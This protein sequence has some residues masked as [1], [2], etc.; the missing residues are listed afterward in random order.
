MTSLLRERCHFTRQLATLVAAGLPLLDSLSSMAKSEQSTQMRHLI[1]QLCV[2]LEQGC[3]FHLALR[4]LNY[5]DTLYCELVGA[6]EMA[7]NLDQVLERLAVL[8]EKRQALHSQIRTALAYPCA[9]L[10]ITMVV[11]AVI[12]VWVVPVF[13][14]IFSS[15]GAD[16]PALTMF[17]L[18]MSRWLSNGGAVWALLALCSLYIP[19]R[20]VMNKPGF[21]LWRDTTLLRLPLFGA[22]VHQSQLSLWT[23]T[24]SDLLKAGVP[25]LD[26]LEVVAA[27][28]TNRCLG[29]STIFIRNKIKHGASLEGAMSSLSSISSQAHVFPPMLI[30][31]IAVGEQSGSLD[32][33]LAK[34]SQQLNTQV[35]NLLRQFTQLLEPAM[36]VVL[37]LLMGGL[38]VALYLPVF[39]L[40]QLL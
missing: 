30:Q 34:M 37:G 21:Q 22:M 11:V 12:M 39:Q 32:S 10:L 27:S 6:A 20:S 7:G 29:M 40:G 13:E 1:A 8:L 28:S 17:V 5:F 26:A 36:M 24:L 3:S 33:L 4:H 18:Q 23:L 16:L 15:L 19:A 25:L 35:D 9:V 38:V 14:G 2:S 31:L